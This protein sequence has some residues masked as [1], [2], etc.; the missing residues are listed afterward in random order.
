M[1]VSVRLP[2]QLHI[3][4]VSIGPEGASIARALG[5][6]RHVVGLETDP[7]PLGVQLLQQT[8]DEGAK[9]CSG[10]DGRGVHYTVDVT[11]LAGC[12]FFIV[13]TPVPFDAY[14]RPDLRGLLD[15]VET[16]GR[17]LTPGSI[18][19]IHSAVPPGTTEED[20]V[21]VLERASGLCEGRD[22]FVGYCAYKAAGIG[23]RNDFKPASAVL[24]GSAPE[25]L[26][27]LRTVYRG[28][29][30]VREVDGIRL[31]EAARFVGDL[32]R[33]VNRALGNELSTICRGLGIDTMALLDAAALD[34]RDIQ[35]GPALVGADYGALS[36]YCLTHRLWREGLQAE[37][38]WVARQING[39]MTAS[40]V[41]QLDEALR[42]GCS[43][44]AGARVLVM[45]LAARADSAVLDGSHV[46]P[47]LDE[48]A[49]ANAHVD[50]YDPWVAKEEARIIGR[51]RLIEVPL[52]GT[53]DAVMIA[54]PHLQFR[55]LNEESL[56]AICKPAHVVFDLCHAQPWTAVDLRL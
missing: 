48:L 10:L 51:A 45:G 12:N 43:R 17:A 38:P 18:V 33:Q 14:G 56:R 20:C 1:S 31:A 40:V 22:F 16:V 35:M 41:R 24:A 32:Y 4:V 25:L 46:L 3:A 44:I 7:H 5:L 37:L 9:A 39:G 36:Y 54:T 2:E 42:R 8:S 19:V 6:E 52:P 23:E 55:N 34:A 28:F 47:L 21:P 26:A 11:E 50:V 27:S 49:R 13:T 29:A 30:S 15:A 53:Y